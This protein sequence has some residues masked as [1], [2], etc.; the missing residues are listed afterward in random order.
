MLNFCDTLSL[1][2]NKKD[3][4]NK[5]RLHIMTLHNVVPPTEIELKDALIVEIE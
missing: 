2:D 3:A 5:W 1:C 4:P